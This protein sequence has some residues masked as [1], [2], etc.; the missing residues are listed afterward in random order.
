MIN[1]DNM[2]KITRCSV[3]KD[4]AYM[5]YRYDLL[6]SFNQNWH[7]FYPNHKFDADG[8]TNA[9]D[10]QGG[11]LL[12]CKS[13]SNLRSGSALGQPESWS[14]SWQWSSSILMM[15]ILILIWVL[16]TCFD[17]FKLFHIQWTTWILLWWSHHL[18]RSRIDRIE[19]V[20]YI[21]HTHI[22]LTRHPPN[23]DSGCLRRHS[24]SMKHP[25]GQA[26]SFVRRRF[27]ANASPK[28]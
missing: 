18:T 8:D 28:S 10:A 11:Q 6:Y 15:I 17:P 23:P 7:C 25:K 27:S 1:I 2:D 19:W 26:R 22:Q 13:W 14:S 21:I 24:S 3:S 16:L 9:V 4:R 20:K 12:Q 5:L